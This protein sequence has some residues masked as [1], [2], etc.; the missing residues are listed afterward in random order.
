MTAENLAI[1]INDPLKPY[2]KLKG[3]NVLGEALSGSVYRKAYDRLIT[4][5]QKQLFVPIIQWIDRTSV[6]GNDRFSLKPYMFQPF[7]RKIQKEYQGMGLS[8]LSPKEEVLISSEADTSYGRC[9]S[10][11]S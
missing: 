6:T 5:P 2:H 10:Y 4:D 11:L 8:W 9:H 3:S 7:Y 1:D